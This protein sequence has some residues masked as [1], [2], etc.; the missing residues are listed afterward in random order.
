MRTRRLPLVAVAALAV[1]VHPSAVFAWGDEGHRIV[2]TIAAHRLTPHAKAAVR[3]LLKKDATGTTLPA[4]ATWADVVRRT[5][6]K[7]TYNWHFV[8]IPVDHGQHT[9]DEARDCHPPDE[10]T[11]GDCVINALSREVAKLNDKSVPIAKRRQALKFVT[12][13]IGDL[14]QPLHCAE[15]DHDHGANDV[16]V[17]FFG[18]THQPAPYQKSLWN[19][20]ATWDFGLITHAGGSQVAYVQRLQNWI[21]TQNASS[22]ESGSYADWANESHA[23]SAAHSYKLADGTTDFPATGGTITQPYHDAN[24]GVVDQQ[25]AKAGV[26]LAKVL[27]EAF[28]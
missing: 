18:Q 28:P 27:N 3:R 24:V 16:K 13:F 12:H 7:E 17:T 8:D 20:H 25:L 19:L 15:R 2:A 14:H 1:A 23:A 26:R 9:Y 22:L 11:K 6:R 10:A 4:V 5:T 21:G